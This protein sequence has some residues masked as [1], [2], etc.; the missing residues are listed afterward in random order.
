VVQTSAFG[1]RSEHSQDCCQAAG[2]PQVH[3]EVMIA[4]AP[5]ASLLLQNTAE[6]TQVMES[7]Q[8]IL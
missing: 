6:Q 1:N 3:T 4:E 7:V 2:L 8:M 5:A